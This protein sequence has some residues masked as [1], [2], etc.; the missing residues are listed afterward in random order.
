[1][2][3]RPNPN[4]HTDSPL[5]TASHHLIAITGG[6]QESCWPGPKRDKAALTRQPAPRSRLRHRQ[7]QHNTNKGASPHPLQHSTCAS[8]LASSAS[9]TMPSRCASLPTRKVRAVCLDGVGS[10]SSEYQ[11]FRPAYQI[12]HASESSSS[13]RRRS[14]GSCS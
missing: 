12:M 7:R 5:T 3:T 4:S 2:M 1:M 8:S 11:R 14:N 9:L 6:L 13:F 10:S